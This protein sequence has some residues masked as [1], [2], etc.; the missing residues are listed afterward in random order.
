MSPRD[1]ELAKY[2]MWYRK[3]RN[4]GGRRQIGLFETRSGLFVCF[5]AIL[6]PVSKS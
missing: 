3:G 6:S 2:R 5:R 4:D 1:E